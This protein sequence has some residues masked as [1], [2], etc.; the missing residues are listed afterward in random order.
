MEYKNV[1][2]QNL[3][4]FFPSGTILVRRYKDYA[5]VAVRDKEQTEFTI[6]TSDVVFV[7]NISEQEVIYRGPDGRLT[8]AFVVNRCTRNSQATQVR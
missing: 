7:S 2:D 6:P 8:S 1:L 3:E 4:R 5:D